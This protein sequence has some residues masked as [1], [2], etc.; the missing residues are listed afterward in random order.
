MAKKLI[1]A[2]RGAS[3]YA[4]ENTLGAFKAAIE[5][6]ADMIEF[7][8]RKTKDNVLVLNHNPTHFAQGIAKLTRQELMDLSES[9]VSL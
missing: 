8:V 4:P 6:G 7:D 9:Q 2:H 5:M 3:A 1:I